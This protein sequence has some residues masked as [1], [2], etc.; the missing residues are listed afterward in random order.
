MPSIRYVNDNSCVTNGQAYSVLC[1]NNF[2]PP[3]KSFRIE[4]SNIGAKKIDGGLGYNV[5]VVNRHTKNLAK[6]FFS[7]DLLSES[8]AV[9]N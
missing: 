4:S 6:K 8:H 3:N 9:L 2:S 1:K 5:A 7:V